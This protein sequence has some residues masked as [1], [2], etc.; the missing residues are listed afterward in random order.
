MSKFGK[1]SLGNRIKSYEAV[2][3][4]HTVPKEAIILRIYGNSLHAFTKGMKKTF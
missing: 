3:K 4:Q 2:Y 1:G